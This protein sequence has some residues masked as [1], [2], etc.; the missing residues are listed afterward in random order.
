MTTNDHKWAST[1]S[2]L[3]SHQLSGVK[4]SPLTKKPAL[5]PSVFG[6]YEEI[7]DEYF[8]G[9]QKLKN[10][11]A[12]ADERDR[13]G[14]QIIL[15]ALSNGKITLSPFHEDLIERCKKDQE[16]YLSKQSDL[17]NITVTNG[18]YR[19][20]VTVEHNRF[21]KRFNDLIEAQHWRDR[22]LI[23]NSKIKNV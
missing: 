20:R 14:L 8:S 16:F 2:Y 19:V 13:G 12:L 10:K 5:C 3:N 9:D 6:D 11:V 18:H 21:D 1:T 17:K 23:L 15:N 22:M 7:I 4:P